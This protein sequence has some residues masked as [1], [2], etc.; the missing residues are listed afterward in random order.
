MS[1]RKINKDEKRREIAISCA[2]KIHCV[3]MK[4]ITVSEVAKMAGV[5][6]GTIYEYF[7][8]KEDI[9]FEI[10]NIHI[11][12][13]HKEII[14][15]I[16]KLDSVREKVEVFFKFVLDDSEE[17]MAHFNGYREFLA[18]VLAED[19]LKMKEF[20]RN[21]NDFFKNE[22]IKILEQGVQKDQLKKEAIDLAEGILTYQKGLALRKMS[23]ADFDTKVNFQKFIDTIF[24]LLEIKQ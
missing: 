6:K 8:N 10:M 18:T 4:N 21:K 16:S 24:K 11:E 9:V 20:N 3:G 13:Y 5:G 23:Q 22:L 17:N 19:N 15:E 7:D 14:D 12:Q 1:P 2:D